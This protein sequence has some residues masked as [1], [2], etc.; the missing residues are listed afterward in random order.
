MTACWWP[1]Q[2]SNAKPPR[3]G[4]VRGAADP[5]RDEDLRRADV[6]IAM[7]ESEHRPMVEQ[8]FSA[9]AKRIRYWKIDDVPEVPAEIAI[10]AIETQVR[11]LIDKLRARH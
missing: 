7:K 11:A 4:P 8:R 3:G 9:F 6:V 1:C 5:V 10:A 2:P